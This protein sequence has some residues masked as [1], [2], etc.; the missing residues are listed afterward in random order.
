LIVIDG[1]GVLI[2]IDGQVVQ[3]L[4]TKDLEESCYDEDLAAN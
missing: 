3:D 4:L 1:Q 2:D